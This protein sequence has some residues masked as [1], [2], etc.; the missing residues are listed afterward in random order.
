MDT[1]TPWLRRCKRQGQGDAAAI[2]GAELRAFDDR[3]RCRLVE[4]L[5][6]AADG[7]GALEALE[8]QRPALDRVLAGRAGWRQGGETRS[9]ALQR[10]ALQCRL[11]RNV[12][13]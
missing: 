6:E 7:R 10:R 5:A 8:L 9:G 2:E 1:K 11:G 13:R 3:L 12:Q 4:A